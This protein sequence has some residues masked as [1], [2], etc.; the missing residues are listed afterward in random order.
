MVR[1][2]IYLRHI[3]GKYDL[4]RDS[5]CLS[6]PSQ[7]TLCDYTYYN[8]ACTGFSAGTDEELVRVLEGSEEWQKI[9]ILLLDE[10]YIKENIVYNK[11]RG[12]IV[13]FTDVN[14]HLL[15][16]TYFAILSTPAMGKNFNFYRTDWRGLQ[17][18]T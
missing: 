5:G 16:E 10:M 15:S 17:L 7:R 11:H 12:R 18:V 13:G 8:K 9:V 3:A 6:L 4:L 2:C 14:N 1:W